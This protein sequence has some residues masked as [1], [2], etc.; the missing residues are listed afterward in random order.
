MVYV[1]NDNG[2]HGFTFVKA[3]GQDGI[4]EES[5][6]HRLEQEEAHEFEWR[7]AD[8]VQPLVSIGLKCKTKTDVLVIGASESLRDRFDVAPSTPA[9]RAAWT[10]LGTLVSTVATAK[11]DLDP[12]ELEQGLWYEMD[13]TG[14][15]R[16]FVFLA[17]ELE[18]GAGFAE[19]I[20]D[21]TFFVD[22][23]RDALGDNFGQKYES[24][25]VHQCD[26][27]CYR[28]LRSYANRQTHP[29]LDWRLAIDFCHL[30]LGGEIP[31][32]AHDYES[33]A[34]ALV[35]TDTRYTLVD[36]GPLYAIVASAQ[37]SIVFAHPFLRNDA[38]WARQASALR[39]SLFDWIRLKHIIIN[40]APDPSGALEVIAP[41][42][43][44]AAV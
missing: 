40:G 25:A 11:L 32:R 39:T 44:I 5:E 34:A 12:H 13:D 8:Y 29:L 33:A 43:F 2:G 6:R 4:L 37:K 35:K 28:C 1:V 10:S 23:L 30:L 19:Q 24:A 18:N 22:V 42:D 38:G 26:S 7:R 3:L 9:R 36:V 15:P 14:R 16:A 41:G 31:G 20:A 17:D 27:S 21:P